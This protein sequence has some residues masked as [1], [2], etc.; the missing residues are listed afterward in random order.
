MIW[1]YT[2]EDSQP[3]LELLVLAFK[4]QLQGTSLVALAFNLALACK[5][6]EEE[7]QVVGKQAK[8]CIEAL[9]MWLFNRDASIAGLLD[10]SG[11]VQRD[12][13]SSEAWRASGSD[14]VTHSHIA[15]SVAAASLDYSKSVVSIVDTTFLGTANVVVC[16]LSSNVGTCS[17]SD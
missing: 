13:E 8:V 3:L 5:Q 12:T 14:T 15:N 2:L 11:E 6:L 17:G 10:L 1:S 9:A 7:H 16:R 4:A